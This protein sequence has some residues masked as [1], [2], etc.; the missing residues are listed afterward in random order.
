[1]TGHVQERLPELR[2]CQRRSRSLFFLLDDQS[3]AQ[4]GCAGGTGYNVR[5]VSGRGYSSCA[6]ERF[7]VDVEPAAARR[8]DAGGRAR[9]IRCRV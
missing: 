4:S 3:G 2:L 1:M 9:S 7:A 6:E 5:A 8:T